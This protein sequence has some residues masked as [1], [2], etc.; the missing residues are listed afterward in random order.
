[1]RVGVMRLGVDDG[2]WAWICDELSGCG[3]ADFFDPTV[4]QTPAGRVLA[5][6]WRALLVL[7]S[8]DAQPPEE[9][10][11]LVHPLAYQELVIGEG[12]EDIRR[13]GVRI[14]RLAAAENLTRA[15][16]VWDL[17]GE[18]SRRALF[19]RP[20]RR[21]I[22][23]RP[24]PLLQSDSC[25]AA[26]GCRVCETACPLGA[27]TFNE[28]WLEVKSSCDGCGLCGA[29]CPTGALA[30]P[31]L[32]DETLEG[33]LRGLNRW[34]E[35]DLILSCPNFEGEHPAETAW[36]EIPCLASLGPAQL[37]RLAAGAPDRV[38]LHCP[39]PDSCNLASRLAQVADWLEWAASL[40]GGPVLGL[41]SLPVGRDGS[42]GK[43]RP[44]GPGGRRE[45]LVGDLRQLG[46]VG[47]PSAVLP[48]WPAWRLQVAEIC[49][50]CGACVGACPTGALKLVTDSEG[51]SLR[52]AMEACVGCG[53][54]AAICPEG[55]VKLQAARLGELTGDKLLLAKDEPRHCR[56]C[57]KILGGERL[58]RKVAARLGRSPEV[59]Q[60]CNDCRVA[61]SLGAKMGVG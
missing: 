53:H 61:I 21:V 31:G 14:G 33:A 10:R 28:G 54:C 32:A 6:G 38:R 18:V 55:S 57:G 3:G 48:G 52:L 41:G 39:E 30:V 37:V 20:L 17:D 51:P 13:I 22:G 4:R 1:M 5:A 24:D 50:L 40:P 60:L 35:G 12:E 29:L 47:E 23:H 45:V 19:R 49:T 16:E 34:P 25:L 2:R 26:A 7:R 27:V 42:R 46:E 44:R 56:R 15:K 8:P 11:D 36:E 9:W 43:A 58:E 59:S